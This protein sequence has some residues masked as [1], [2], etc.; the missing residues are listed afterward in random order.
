M[1][2]STR[3]KDRKPPT[4]SPQGVLQPLRSR[5]SFAVGIYVALIVASTPIYLLPVITAALSGTANAAY[6][7]IALQVSAVLTLVPTQTGQS[8]LSDLSQRPERLVQAPSEPSAA[9]TWSRCRWRSSS[10]FLTLCTAHLRLTLFPP[11]HFVSEVERREQ[12]LL[13]IQ[14]RRRRRP[15]GAPPGEGLRSCERDGY[16][17]PDDARRGRP[18]HELLASRSG[19]VRRTGRV[20]DGVG[21]DPVSLREQRAAWGAP[22]TARR[23]DTADR[24]LAGAPGA[25]IWPR[26]GRRTPPGV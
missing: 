26:A 1:I 22:R 19:M 10:G 5:F 9:P 2:L 3:L 17:N 13:R 24:S 21:G 4:G 11:R 18:Q 23:H 8:L 14:L 7:A 15:A 12:R 16:G 6:I 25:T 20:R